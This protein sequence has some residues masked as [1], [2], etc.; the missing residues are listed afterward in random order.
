MQLRRSIR[1]AVLSGLLVLTGRVTSPTGDGRAVLL[2]EVVEPTSM[3]C[4][5]PCDFGDALA[6]VT[7]WNDTIRWNNALR[8]NVV[9]RRNAETVTHPVGVPQ[10]TGRSTRH[11]A[12]F[13]A[14]SGDC[15]GSLP[16]CCVLRRESGGNI[17][18]QN[19]V[20]SA[21]GKWQ[22]LDSTWGGY[23]GYQHAKDAPADVQDARAR[24]VFAGGA[25]ASHWAGGGC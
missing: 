19:P 10:A 1:V 21:S 7:L 9:V 20:S 16:S 22:F 15:G 6:R 5:I 13:A 2:D 4:T 18:A 23:G 25:G 24:I 14:V 8:W 11:V 12:V 3:T 17:R